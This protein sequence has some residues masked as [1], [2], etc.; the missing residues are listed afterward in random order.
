MSKWA[1]LSLILGHLEDED[2][3][4]EEQVSPELAPAKTSNYGKLVIMKNMESVPK[5]SHKEAKG[6]HIH[7]AG[8]KESC[9]YSGFIYSNIKHCLF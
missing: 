1:C 8:V 9:Y 4:K 2:E 6:S 3:D 5:R 7:D